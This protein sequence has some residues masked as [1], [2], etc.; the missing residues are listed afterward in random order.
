VEEDG[1]E[2]WLLHVDPPD[3]VRLQR[4]EELGED[5]LG[6]GDP[7]D[8]C[9]PLAPDLGDARDRTELGLVHGLARLEFDEVR[10]DAG[11]EGRGRSPASYACRSRTSSPAP[12]GG[13]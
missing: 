10:L 7:E 8:P 13:L 11:L 1:L 12:F 6:R 3:R 9:C 2:T 5:L 4:R